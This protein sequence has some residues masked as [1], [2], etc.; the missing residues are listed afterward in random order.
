MKSIV[1]G[2][3]G[4]GGISLCKLI[5]TLLFSR[6][7]ISLAEAVFFNPFIC[8]ETGDKKSSVGDNGREL[9]VLSLPLPSRP[10]PGREPMDL[11]CS[12]LSILF[13]TKQLETYSVYLYIYLFRNVYVSM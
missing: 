13:F 6:L 4:K 5:G 7:L 2:G 9:F 1:F 12:I 8:F 3:K 10:L 11:N